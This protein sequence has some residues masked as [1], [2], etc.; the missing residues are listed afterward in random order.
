MDGMIRLFHDFRRLPDIDQAIDIW[1]RADAEIDQ[2][3]A[4]GAQIHSAVQSG[5]T[6]DSVMLPYLK[7]LFAVN[8][9]L[10]PMEDASRPRWAKRRARPS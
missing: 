1:T 2:L 5:R 7:A 3:L 4:L 10:M 9:R 8:Q 6:Q